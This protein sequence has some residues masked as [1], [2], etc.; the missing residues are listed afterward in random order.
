M[1][2]N[3]KNEQKPEVNEKKSRKKTILDKKPKTPSLEKKQKKS[4]SE[5]K[6]TK[7]A[8]FASEQEYEHYR[9]EPLS[10]IFWRR[11]P[12]ENGCDTR[13]LSEEEEVI[14]DSTLVPDNRE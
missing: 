10:P 9:D 1:Q 14:F 13:Q 3:E 2:K 5:K 11:M 8:F 6:P 4:V 12:V 7:K